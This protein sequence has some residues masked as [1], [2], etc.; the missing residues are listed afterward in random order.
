MPLSFLVSVLIVVIMRFMIVLLSA[1]YEHVEFFVTDVSISH[2]LGYGVSSISM[3]YL[4][5]RLLGY[6]ISSKT[7]STHI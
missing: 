1:H 3:F 5:A 7:V 6:L 2:M 4:H